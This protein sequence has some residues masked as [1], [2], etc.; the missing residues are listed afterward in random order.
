[1]DAGGV[2]RGASMADAAFNKTRQ[3]AEKMGRGIQNSSKQGVDSL[4]KLAMGA[5]AVGVPLNQLGSKGLQFFKGTIGEAAKLEGALGQVG[6]VMGKV[7]KGAKDAKI[8]DDFAVVRKE[9]VR[10]GRDTEFATSQAA[11][12]FYMLKSAGIKTLDAKDLMKYTMALSSASQGQIDLGQAAKVTGLIYNKFGLDVKQTSNVLNAMV[13]LTQET[14]VQFRDLRI[15]L[16]SLGAVASKFT[17]TSAYDMLAMAGTLKTMGLSAAQSTQYIAGFARSVDMILKVLSGKVKRGKWKKKIYEEYGLSREDFVDAT[18][19]YRNMIEIINRL[20]KKLVRLSAADRGVAYRLIFGAD[21]PATLMTLIQTSSKRMGQSMEQM[22]AKLKNAG[23]VAME[24]QKMYLKTW[25]GQMQV[26]QGSM[27]LMKASLGMMFLPVLKPMIELL[28][29]LINKFVEW[30]KTNPILYKTLVGIIVLILI[31]SKLAGGLT[32]ALAGMAV[33]MRIAGYSGAGGAKGLA[34]FKIALGHLWA[35]MAPILIPLAKFILIAAAIA[36]AGYLLY[37]AWKHF[38][39]LWSDVEGSIAALGEK[40]VNFGKRVKAAVVWFFTHPREAARSLAR[41][42]IHG[43]AWVGKALYYL[44]TWPYQVMKLVVKHWDKIIDTF[45]TGVN[46]IWDALVAAGVA[47]GKWIAQLWW[48]SL[49]FFAELPFMIGR[50]LSKALQVLGDFLR[51]FA[52][53]LL[54]GFVTALFD[55]MNAISNF[56]K[57]LPGE[58][59]N[60]GKGI[61]NAIIQG[62]KDAVKYLWQTVKGVGQ[63]VRDFFPFSPAKEGPLQTLDKGGRGIVSQ[64]I[65]GIGL[66]SAKMDVAMN[67]VLSGGAQPLDGGAP[68]TTAPVAAVGGSVSVHIGELHFHAQRLN[69]HEAEIFTNKMMQKL[70]QRMKEYRDRRN[71]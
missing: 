41:A 37:K 49:K 35:A 61:I 32:M 22:S 10:I 64:V 48:D 44:A 12:G 69:E 56:V 1:M 17:K 11:S 15:M 7:G 30:G 53:G 62:I 18:G 24:G 58:F 40:F 71:V 21:M 33:M 6:L 3:S 28:T 51:E 70:A 65:K 8:K 31:M 2:V 60:A 23:N 38:P 42:I 36:A 68:A 66:E 43:I 50:G 19:N 47:A 34:L 16:S 20:N 39:N 26:M 63:K 29:K 46:S 4:S 59:Y 5:G 45:N 55:V 14:D 27:E 13:K 57:K 52:K 54:E 25:K 9:I 67:H